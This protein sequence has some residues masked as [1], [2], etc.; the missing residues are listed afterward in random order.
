VERPRDD[1]TGTEPDPTGTA[2]ASPPHDRPSAPRRFDPADWQLLVSERRRRLMDPGAF[3]D[4]V[5]I[6]AGATVADVGAGP[7]F[8]TL[9]LA[10]RVGPTGH[11]YATDVAP[12]M[13]DRLRAADP[14]PWVEPL[15]APDE[16]QVPIGDT[17]VELALFAFVLHELDDPVRFLRDLRRTLRPGGRLVLLEWVPHDEPIGPPHAE[18]LSQE[19]SATL[20]ETAGFT[21]VELGSANRSQYYLIAIPTP[22]TA[23]PRE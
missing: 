1:L 21:V 16:H 7:G 11:V 14:P 6:P 20:V 12:A 2:S 9:P 5:G 3:L 19:A 13:L 18:R 22:S 4:R 10:E 15:L 17:A 8:Y 23:T